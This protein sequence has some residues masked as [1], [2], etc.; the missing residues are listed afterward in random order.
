MIMRIARI[1]SA[2]PDMLTIGILAWNA[3][4]LLAAERPTAHNRGPI[5]TVIPCRPERQC[6]WARSVFGKTSESSGLCIHP[7]AD[8]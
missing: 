7:T 3:P 4:V 8:T 2:V 6:V 5:A 1:P